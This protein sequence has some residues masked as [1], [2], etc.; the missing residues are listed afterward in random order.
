MHV[1]CRRR[2][3][4]LW[5]IAAPGIAGARVVGT[6]KFPAQRTTRDGSEDFAVILIS[7]IRPLTSGFDMFRVK[8]S[9]K[10][11]FEIK[12]PVDRVQKFFSDLGNFTGLLPGVESIRHELGGIARWT[13][14]TNTPVGRVRLSLPVRET[15][16]H[17]NVIEWSPALQESENLLRYSLKFETRNGATAVTISQQVELRRKRAWDLHPGVALM[18]EARISAALQRR[19]NEAIEDFLARV[20]EKL[21]SS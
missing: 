19:I 18:G 6:K 12:A 17:T 5:T 13:I 15:S 20:K 2:P 16:P 3:I 1:D 14:A 8:S 11:E 4:I 9:F 21:E 7:D 10:S